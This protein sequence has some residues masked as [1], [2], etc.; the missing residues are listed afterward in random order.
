MGPSRS[1]AKNYSSNF[2]ALLDCT[3][4]LTAILAWVR[5]MD[6]D[7]SIYAARPLEYPG[8]ALERGRHALAATRTGRVMSKHMPKLPAD[9]DH[10]L[11]FEVQATSVGSGRWLAGVGKSPSEQAMKARLRGLVPMDS[12]H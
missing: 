9:H 4:H 12:I 3:K 6:D 10:P 2:S 5:A 8:R 7:T 1:V 11:N